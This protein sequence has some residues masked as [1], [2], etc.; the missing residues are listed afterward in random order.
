MTRRSLFLSLVVLTT[1]VMSSAALGG[2]LLDTLLRVSGLTVAPTQLRGPGDDVQEGSL[3]IANLDRQTV[4]G[5]TRDVGYRSPVFSLAG[6]ALVALKGDMLV[7]IP[8][9][10]GTAVAVRKVTGVLKLVGFDGDNSDRIVVLLADARLPLAALSLKT[11]TIASLPYDPA[12]PEERRLLAQ[13]RGQT[14]VYG[15]TTLYTK[16]ES[17]QGLSRPIEWT[18]V[19]I[20]RGGGVPV[21]V[22]RCDGVSCD[23]PA[24][25]ADGRQVAFVKAGG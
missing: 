9:E 1:L 4:V 3:W 23:Q 21:N 13:I 7:R 15:V 5:I 25:S 20:Q 22:S 8:V 16:T 24:L 6:D 17:K 11:G 19:F 10:S 12:S 2:S 14:R 18:D